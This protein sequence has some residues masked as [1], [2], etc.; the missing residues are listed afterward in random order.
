MQARQCAR[1]VSD[2]LHQLSFSRLQTRA[3]DTTT[4]VLPTDILCST[5]AQA[6]VSQASAVTSIV[7]VDHTRSVYRDGSPS[8]AW[9]NFLFESQLMDRWGWPSITWNGQWVCL[10]QA[11]HPRASS[12]PRK[13]RPGAGG[14]GGGPKKRTKVECKGVGG[15]TARDPASVS[16]A[17][18]PSSPMTWAERGRQAQE[19]LLASHI[20]FWMDRLI[21][22]SDFKDQYTLDSGKTKKS[23]VFGITRVYTARGCPLRY[24]I[25]EVVLEDEGDAKHF[26]DE[27]VLNELLGGPGADAVAPAFHAAFLVYHPGLDT[28]KGYL[29]NDAY[30]MSMEDYIRDNRSRRDDDSARFVRFF[31]AK[32]STLAQTGF[33]FWDL[34]PANVVVMKQLRDV[35]LIDWDT[36][37]GMYWPDFGTQGLSAHERYIVLVYIF[38]MNSSLRAGHWLLLDMIAQWSLARDFNQHWS[39]REKLV[40][41][42]DQAYRQSRG[43]QTDTSPVEVM[44]H[45]KSPK[46]D[47]DVDKYLSKLTGKPK[48]TTG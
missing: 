7:L 28:T 16:A 47:A 22:E 43:T 1:C 30:D 13:K 31:L 27:A 33:M 17:L 38:L 11:L 29:V 32:V 12:G 35:R 37:Y 10:C 19:S 4:L 25:K 36:N 20:P 21:S 26:R 15:P 23:G 41:R 34:K 44:A 46:A 40:S 18:K 39:R 2:S 42:L 8:Q 3:A 45:Y 48:A 9:L 24:R 14:A 5:A 6:L